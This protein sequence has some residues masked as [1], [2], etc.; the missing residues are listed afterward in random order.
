MKSMRELNRYL[1]DIARRIIRDDIR[2]KD[3][4]PA[5][6][7]AL[8]VAVDLIIERLKEES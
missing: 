6:L 2:G 7:Y 1:T 4:N 3:P 8:K 5:D